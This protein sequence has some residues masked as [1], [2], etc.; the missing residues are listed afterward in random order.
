M[1]IGKERMGLLG[2]AGRYEGPVVNVSPP[3]FVPLAVAWQ[4]GAA[5]CAQ[6]CPRIS[7]FDVADFVK[8]LDLLAGQVELS[9]FA[10]MAVQKFSGYDQEDMARDECAACRT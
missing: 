3:S 1:I 5:N 9:R 6:R 8:R 4:E 2:S 10:L 7:G